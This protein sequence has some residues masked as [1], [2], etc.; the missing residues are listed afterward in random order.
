MKFDRLQQECYDRAAF[1]CSKSEKSSGSIGKKLLDWGLVPD[2]AEPVLKK[3]IDEKF[4]DDERFARSYV[5]DKFRFNKWGKIKIAWQ[6]R[7]EK[8]SGSIIARAM[9]EIEEEAYMETLKKL[10]RD[11]SKTIRSANPYDRRGKLLRFAQS[12]GFEPELIHSAIDKL[13]A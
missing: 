6:L 11:K 1:L 12:H 13:D 7:A 4:I 10:L 9:E 3:L 2:D 8:V 5:K